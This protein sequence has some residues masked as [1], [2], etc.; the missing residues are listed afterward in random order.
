MPYNGLRISSGQESVRIQNEC[1][2]LPIF[3]SDYAAVHD[4]N[5]LLIN[6]VYHEYQR[7]IATAPRSCK[8]RHTL[9]HRYGLGH[10][11]RSQ[12]SHAVRNCIT[13]TPGLSRKQAHPL[14][15]LNCFIYVKTHPDI[16]SICWQASTVLTLY[17]FQ[18]PNLA[19]NVI[20]PTVP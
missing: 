13:Q 7:D 17:I 16:P 14:D 3:F 19:S 6:F 11:L 5:L 18:R 8:P 9:S 1:G 15:R 4:R 10:R 2:D 12:R 20:A